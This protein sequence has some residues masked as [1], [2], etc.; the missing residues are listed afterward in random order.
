MKTRRE[1]KLI[2]RLGMKNQWSTAICAFLI[3]MGIS[4]ILSLFM[5]VPLINVVPFAIIYVAAVS[6]IRPYIDIYRGT[7]ADAEDVVNGMKVH[8]F[9]KLGS[10]LLV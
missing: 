10:V 8:F 4:T 9:R 5:W 3:F 1:I 2:A 7:K 6:Y